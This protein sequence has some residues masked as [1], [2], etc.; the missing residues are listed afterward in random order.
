MQLSWQI[1]GICLSMLSAPA[2]IEWVN[3]KVHYGVH[4][5]AFMISTCFSS[6]PL[7]QDVNGLA[8]KPANKLCD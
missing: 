3:V 2:G 6:P 8:K 5:H 1:P 7:G 4:F